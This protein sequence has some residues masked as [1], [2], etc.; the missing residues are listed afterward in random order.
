MNKLKE[1]T[2]EIKKVVKGKDEVSAKILMAITAGGHVLLEDMPGVGKTTLALCFAKAMDLD[3]KRIQF[4]PDVLASDI[5]G[6][7]MYNVKTQEFEFKDGMAMCNLLL[8]D[9][10]NRTSPRTQS[11]L[12]EVMEEGKVTVDAITKELPKPFFVI[13]TQNPFGSFGTQRMPQSQLDRF[14]IRLSMGYPDE[15]SEIE[16]LKGVRGNKTDIISKITDK[17]SILEIQ[18]ECSGVFVDD[19]L[20]NYIV[21]L[22]NETR[23]SQYLSG[24]LSPRG[25]IA[26]LKMSKANA[27]YNDRD[28]IIPEDIIDV[29]YD[30]C[31]HRIELSTKAKGEGLNEKDV[32]EMLRK[33]IKMPKVKR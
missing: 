2:E 16:I 6:Y 18:E 30:V 5:M 17:K 15:K 31:G 9:E 7:F 21:S 3:Y 1:I 33:K 29:L 20:Y 4:T 19:S 28:Y 23:N 8:A 24:G 11:A 27:F 12:L 14:I 26:L 32:L 10:I 25:S 22:A 13:A